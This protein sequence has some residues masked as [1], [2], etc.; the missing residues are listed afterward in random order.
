[1]KRTTVLF[2]LMVAP[3]LGQA[4]A[5]YLYEEAKVEP[6]RLPD[7]LVEVQNSG[8][9]WRH[10]RPEILRRFEDQVYG[11][12][13]R[14]VVNRLEWAQAEGPAPV[15]DGLG[16]REQISVWPLGRQ[17]GVK[18]NLLLYRPASSEPVPVFLG[19]NFYGNQTVYPDPAIK[20]A[21][22]WVAK[23]Q[24]LGLDGHRATEAS[25]GTR[26]S[27][28]PVEAILQRGYGLC[29]LYYGDADPDRD[30]FSDGVHAVTGVPGKGEWGSIATWAWALSRVQ[31]LS[32]IHI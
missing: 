4:P 29:T 9:W 7:P 28:W 17:A 5:G 13:P 23:N 10:R 12:V 32:L 26:A 30:D 20:L 25:R 8:D 27:R 24:S 19:M 2:L 18:L 6:Y 21:E 1:M 16:W 22:G 31:D 11:A 15:F 14:S 3:L